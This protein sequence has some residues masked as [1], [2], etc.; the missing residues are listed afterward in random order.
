MLRS[1]VLMCH[2]P[3]VIPAIARGE[4]SR[5][6]ATTAAMAQAAARLAASG[7]RRVALLTP[8]AP[9]HGQ[10]FG[11]YGG[12][13]VSGNFGRFGAR[14]LRVEFPGDPE[15]LAAVS[16]AAARRGLELHPVH[17][18]DLDHG[19]LV[20][21]WFLQEAGWRG[22]VAVYGFPWH[23]G[24]SGRVAFGEAL[25]S[26]MERLGSPWALLASGDCSHRLTPGA[27]AGFDP[28]AA[29]FDRRL[30]EAVQEGRESDLGRDQAELRE[31]AAEDVVETLEVTSGVLGED[32]AGRE[33]LSYEGP[34]GVGYCVAVLQEAPP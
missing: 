6:E 12:P 15:A 13:T 25:A 2:A 1:T 19:A 7:A 10:A 26:G 18:R 14:G 8:H 29:Q 28:L 9:R 11:F 22:P 31:L 23:G 16:Q 3:I 32:R 30:V 4:A 5:C 21:L 33:F 24:D 27:P 17:G 34:F 20:P